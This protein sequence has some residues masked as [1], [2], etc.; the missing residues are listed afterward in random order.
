MCFV[1]IF[2]F[3]LVSTLSSSFRL[4]YSVYWLCIYAVA[5]AAAIVS[6]ADKLVQCLCV[7]C[8]SISETYYHCEP[9][10]HTKR[11]KKC[12]SAKK[13]ERKRGKKHDFPFMLVT[14]HDTSQL[15]VNSCV[16][17]CDYY[18]FLF[19]VDIFVDCTSIVHSLHLINII[20]A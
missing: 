11:K 7:F 18:E 13:K 8:E 15:I 4:F 9:K 14:K 16:S 3:I 2:L 10:N 19:G 1:F 12:E 17:M 5:A 20:H 6:S